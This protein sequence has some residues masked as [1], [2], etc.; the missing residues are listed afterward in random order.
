MHSLYSWLS[1]ILAD[2]SYTDDK[3]KDALRNLGD[4]TIEVVKRSDVAKD[5]YSAAPPDTFV[6]LNRNYRLAKNVE[7]TTESSIFWLY[8]ASIKPRSRRLARA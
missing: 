5:F 1:H 7:A 3:L 8:I 2:G 6:W 4:W